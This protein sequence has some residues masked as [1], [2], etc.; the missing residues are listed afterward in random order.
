[1]PWWEGTQQTTISYNEPISIHKLNFLQDYVLFSNSNSNMM[2]S[3]RTF[4]TECKILLWHFTLHRL[5]PFTLPRHY[6]HTVES[7][8]FEGT[9]QTSW[10]KWFC[11]VR[12][13]FTVFFWGGDSTRLNSQCRICNQQTVG[14]HMNTGHWEHKS[15]VTSHWCSVRP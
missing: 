11:K 1:M 6:K 10:S 8:A 15:P 2:M 3:M 9:T 7:S 13:E 12:P 5:F 14:L 4:Q